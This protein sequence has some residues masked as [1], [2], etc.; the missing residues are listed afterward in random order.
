MNNSGKSGFIKFALL[1]IVGVLVLSY[2]NINIQNVAESPQSKSN[3]GYVTR[4]SQAAWHGYLER[5][6]LYFWNNIFISLL[7]DSFVSNL[8]RIKKGE[9]NDF[10]LMA[11]QVPD[12]VSGQS[13]QQ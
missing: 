7:W 11:P 3:F 13:Y 8:E 9:P 1:I 10:D 4:V 2:F 5:P 6:V 12:N